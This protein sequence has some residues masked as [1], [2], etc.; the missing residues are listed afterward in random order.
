MNPQD[1]VFFKCPNCLRVFF[2]NYEPETV[3]KH[4]GV[5]IREIPCSQDCIDEMREWERIMK[6][7]EN[8]A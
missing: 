7:E 2:R 6:E 4:Q 5:R 3:K 1:Y 8:A